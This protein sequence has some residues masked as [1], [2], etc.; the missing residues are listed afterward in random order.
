MLIPAHSTVGSGRKLVSPFKTLKAPISLDFS[1][2]SKINENLTF[3]ED[4]DIDSV[5]DSP[6]RRP[7]KRNVVST[8]GKQI[9]TDETVNNWHGKSFK[10][11]SSD[12]SD[13]DTEEAKLENPFLSSSRGAKSS[14]FRKSDVDYST[15][16][17]YFNHRTGER[18]VE[19]LLESQK[20]FKP[21]KID[22]SGI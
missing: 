11:F 4:E 6:S 7:R 9:I 16:I 15:H 14:S 3:E 17:E 13:S 21:K 2:L 10:C 22:F 1:E 20:K 5:P 12:E 19:E 8:P 18:R